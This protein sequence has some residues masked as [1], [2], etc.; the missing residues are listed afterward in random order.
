MKQAQADSGVVW[1]DGQI[2]DYAAAQVSL[3]DRGFLFGDGVYEV[4]R[5][6]GHKPF[7]LAEH[8]ARLERSANGI[9]LSLPERLEALADLA[10]RLVGMSGIAEAEIYIEVTRGAAQRNHLFPTGVKPTLVV[11]VRRRREVPPALWEM[12]CRVITLPDQRWARC[13]LKTVCLLP[14]VLAKE[15]AHRTGAFEAVLVRDGI[16]TEGTSCNL[17]MVQ[18]G[19]LSTPISDNRILPGITRAVTIGLAKER[20]YEVIERD[21]R[22][23]E[24]TYAQEII[25]TSTSIELMPVVEIDGHRIGDG[26]P[27]P[28]DRELHAAF[29]SLSTPH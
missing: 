16:V 1:I 2:T 3:E 23:E 15:K 28:I 6:Y 29:R 19:I 24:L 11:G 17:F 22:T 20:G 4:I 25:L 7:A 12:G 26:G 14:N 27:G 9:E 18:N 10:H 13:D 5:V 8:L 21:V